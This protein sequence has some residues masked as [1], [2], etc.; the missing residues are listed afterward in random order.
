M[1][2]NST[3]FDTCMC[4]WMPSPMPSAA[5]AADLEFEVVTVSDEVSSRRIP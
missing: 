2:M 4:Q 3:R 1:A 5:A